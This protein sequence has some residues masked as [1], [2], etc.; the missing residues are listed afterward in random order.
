MVTR[1]PPRPSLLST[2][3][4]RD[5]RGGIRDRCVC[6]RETPR[7][8]LHNPQNVTHRCR[9]TLLDTQGRSFHDVHPKIHPQLEADDSDFVLVGGEQFVSS[10]AKK[11]GLAVVAPAR[12]ARALDDISNIVEAELQPW[13]T[14]SKSSLKRRAPKDLPR[15][16]LREGLKKA[17]D[18]VRK[19]MATALTE[20]F[21]LWE[22]ILTEMANVCDRARAPAYEAL[23]RN[24]LGQKMMWAEESFGARRD[25]ADA[26]EVRDE[27]GAATGGDD[28]L[29]RHQANPLHD[30]ALEEAGHR[31]PF[32]SPKREELAR[33]IL[34][35]IRAEVEGGIKGRLPLA[36]FIASVSDNG[37]AWYNLLSKKAARMLGSSKTGSDWDVFETLLK[38]R[39]AVETLRTN[40]VRWEMLHPHRAGVEILDLIPHL[41]PK[42]RGKASA[43]L[44]QA[45]DLLSSSSGSSEERVLVGDGPSNGAAPLANFGT[46]IVAVYLRALFVSLEEDIAELEAQRSAR[47]DHITRVIRHLHISIA[48]GKE[49]VANE[50]RRLFQRWAHCTLKMSCPSV[51]EELGLGDVA[52]D[53]HHSRYGGASA[54][55]PELRY[56]RPG[57]RLIHNSTSDASCQRRS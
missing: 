11:F 49:I 13:L 42:A 35:Q 46:E 53:E 20:C 44:T 9:G 50:F 38:Q 57:I 30:A 43:A 40:F 19:S 39:E 32:F 52:V 1:I 51:Q 2:V 47:L 16:A 34:L 37:G 12:L 7:S 21:V 4:S 26:E 54:A 23:L 31:G 28:D 15:D 56:V 17:N 55:L 10:F 27:D 22:K 3:E 5:G 24:V 36:K 8:S 25:E 6:N 29:D 33:S 18:V 14:G 45:Q 41:S 48:S